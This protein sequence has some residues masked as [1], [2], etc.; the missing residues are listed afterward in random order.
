MYKD[1]EKQKKYQ[2]EWRSKWRLTTLGMKIN[3]QRSKIY[4]EKNREKHNKSSNYW[5]K[6]NRD[7]INKRLRDRYKNDYLWKINC[8]LR[9]RFK[10]IKTNNKYIEF[11]GCS[12]E[13]FKIHLESKFDEG[14]NWEN[15]KEWHIDHIIPLSW[16]IWVKKN[17]LEDFFD[18]HIEE[19]FHYLN[20]RPIWKKENLE[21]GD[22]FILCKNI[23]L[24]G[25]ST[26]L[27]ALLSLT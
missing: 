1:K 10:D 16:F 11:L 7:K 17:N 20:L 18:L 27:V 14:M 24:I 26:P 22:R 25:F 13:D 12:I 19:S 2:R 6:N 9:S 5:A 23:N 4:R 15:K 3:R 8:L 21:K